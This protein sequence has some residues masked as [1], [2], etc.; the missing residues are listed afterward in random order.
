MEEGSMDERFERERIGRRYEDEARLAEERPRDYEGGRYRG[1]GYYGGYHQPSR[2]G[3]SYPREGSVSVRTLTARSPGGRDGW[4][5]GNPI[6]PSSSPPECRSAGRLSLRTTTGFRRP[7]RLSAL[8][9]VLGPQRRASKDSRG[10]DRRSRPN[11]SL[12]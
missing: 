12:S 2:S 7:A 3:G 6:G 9:A 11:S 8:P 10:I 1:E 4:A 5:F